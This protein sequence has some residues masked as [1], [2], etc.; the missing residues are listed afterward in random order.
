MTYGYSDILPIVQEVLRTSDPISQDAQLSDAGL[1]STDTV[2]LFLA[3]EER[4][5]ITF[6][7]EDLVGENFRTIGHVIDITNRAMRSPAG[8]V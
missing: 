1:D 7:D 2:S 3:I 8:A 5:G 6:R 4:L